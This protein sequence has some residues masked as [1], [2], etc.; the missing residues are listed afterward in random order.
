VGATTWCH[1][2]LHMA[3]G[4]G[5]QAADLWYPAIEELSRRR[6]R[7]AK[8]DLTPLRFLNGRVLNGNYNPAWMCARELLTR[9][10]LLDKFQFKP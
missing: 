2:R 7:A 5:Q 4:L 10:H 6:G 8:R 9:N 3:V 1:K